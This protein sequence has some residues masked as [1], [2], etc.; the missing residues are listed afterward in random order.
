MDS[1]DLAALV[2]NAGVDVSRITAK[3]VY[4]H[5]PQPKA[6]PRGDSRPSWSINVETGAH[7]CFACGYRGSLRSLLLDLTG[8]I[9]QDLDVT[10]T[11]AR[12][13]R[14]IAG[15]Q[16][17]LK[18]PE[19]EPDD[20]IFISEYAIRQYA[21][22]PVW[23]CD[24]RYLEPDD[25]DFYGVRWDDREDHWIIPVRSFEGALIGWQEKGHKFFNNTPRGMQKSQS[26]FGLDV[27]HGRRAILVES[28]LD[29]I[30]LASVGI[31]G[32]LSS[33][34]AHV[35][36]EQMERLIGVADT[37]VLALDHD[38]AGRS[39]MMTLI[40]SYRKYTRMKVVRYRREDPKDIGEMQPGMIH[41][42]LRNAVLV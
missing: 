30:R 27:F 41:R 2:E 32:G 18:G 8:E 36:R 28:P 4:A 23:A 16:R 7:F 11:H 35:S 40:G 6:H 31:E 21:K 5:C 20:D 22:P 38:S 3:E 34:G 33:Y 39:A 12:G 29:A 10:I 13:T 25:V 15:A 1:R 17:K 9:P 42:L 14:D 26:L 19:P 24:E 37:V